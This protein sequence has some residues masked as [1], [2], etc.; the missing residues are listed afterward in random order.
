LRSYL[1]H[2]PDVIMVGEIRDL[3]TAEMP[4]Q[5]SL[6]GHLVFATL[7]TNDAPSAFTRLIDMGV[8]PFLV[9]STVIASIA[10][11]LVRKL[12][13]NCKIPYEPE[14]DVLR[15]LGAT[16]E[17]LAEA[18]GHIYRAREGGCDECLDLGYTGRT[19]I[20]EILTVDDEIRQLVTQREDA[21]VI[22]R[23][24]TERNIMRTLRYD[25]ALKVMQGQTS[26]EEVLRVTQ[27][28]TVDVKKKDT[29]A[30]PPEPGAAT[31]EVQ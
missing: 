18:G 9:S 14:Q 13:P 21:S 22:K 8:E 1:R 5:A 24:A 28:D 31:P 2:D 26:I 7:H 29:D 12:C 15:E 4:T 20:F 16:P 27:E 23:S 3:E 17:Q 30:V 10:Q 6:T 19:A 11:R 25:G